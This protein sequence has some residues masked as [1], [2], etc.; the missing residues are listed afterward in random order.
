V[1]PLAQ[2]FVDAFVALAAQ[3]PLSCALT[4]GSAATTLYPHLAQA[5]LDWSKVDFY[6]S[7][8]RC[9]ALDHPDS[10]YRVLKTVLPRARLHAVRTE[11]PPDEAAADYARRLPPR[12]DVVH[13]GVGPDGH[14]ASLFPGHLLLAETHLR[15]AAL[16]DSP[17]PPPARVTFTLPTLCS[18]HQV[19]FLVTGEGKQAAVQAARSDPQSSLPAALVSRGARSSTWFL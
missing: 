16:T 12:L 4:G 3:G 6:V 14:V 17:K 13:L 10:N 9:V 15:V 5:P 8:E 7:D 1:T 2:R 19:W 18:A 11:L